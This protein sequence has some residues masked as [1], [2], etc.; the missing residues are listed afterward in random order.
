M[1]RIPR[2][3]RRG[4]A[5]R[6]GGHR[7]P[8][9]R[10]VGAA[11]RD[12][13]RRAELF[14]QVR[15][16][17]P[18][19]LAHRPDAECRGLARDRAAQVLEQDRHAPERAIGQMAVGLQPGR[20]EPRPDHGVQLRVDRLDAGDGGL[21]QLLGTYLTAPDE[22]GLCRGVQPCHLGHIAHATVNRA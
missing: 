16:Y 20:V 9:L 10:H 8:E 17:R 18:G 13:A 3:A 5:P 2:V 19:H 11:E 22:I 6:F 1:T 15:R 4:E 21:G 7:G 14:R 12:E